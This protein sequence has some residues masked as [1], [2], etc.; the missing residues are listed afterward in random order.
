MINEYFI[1]I[2]KCECRVH[3]EYVDAVVAVNS[4][5]GLTK[6]GGRTRMDS[7]GSGYGPLQALVN[8]TINL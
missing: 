7:S 3:S 1:L 5:L 6:Y 2:R 4:N 8:T